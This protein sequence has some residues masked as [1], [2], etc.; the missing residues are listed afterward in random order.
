MGDTVG[1]CFFSYWGEKEHKSRCRNTNSSFPLPM[2]LSA[3]QL[4]LWPKTSHP[5]L[6]GVQAWPGLLDR[7]DET[8]LP[9][10]CWMLP[11]HV[12]MWYVLWIS[13]VLSTDFTQHLA[14]NGW[15]Q[16]MKQGQSSVLLV[17]TIPTCARWGSP[18]APQLLLAGGEWKLWREAWAYSVQHVPKFLSWKFICNDPDTPETD[19]YMCRREGLHA[20]YNGSRARCT[21]TQPICTIEVICTYWGSHR[22]GVKKKKDI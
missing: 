5:Y 17:P 13:L 18:C 6:G 7:M 12:S 3:A 8:L 22:Q 21:V 19:C 2:T 9:P 11:F 10:G 20:P 15:V 14:S 4:Y 1:L 16:G